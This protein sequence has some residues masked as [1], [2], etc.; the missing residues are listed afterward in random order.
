MEVAKVD[1]VRVNFREVHEPAPTAVRSAI[2][3]DSKVYKTPIYDRS[4]LSAGHTLKGPIIVEQFDT[5]TVVPPDWH[6]SVDAYANL[7]IQPKE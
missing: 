1:P 4:A 2:F 6:V 7:V 5:T 3:E